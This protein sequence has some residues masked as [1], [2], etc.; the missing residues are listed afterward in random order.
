MGRGFSFVRY[1]LRVT[2]VFIS[3]VATLCEIIALNLT[4]KLPLPAS[5]SRA[6][7]GIMKLIRARLISYQ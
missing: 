1:D 4:Q 5:T 2:V 6:T 3:S 7:I